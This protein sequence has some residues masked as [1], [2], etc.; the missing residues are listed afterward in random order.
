MI[1]LR[2]TTPQASA[3]RHRTLVGASRKT[4]LLMAAFATT[5]IGQNPIA[6]ER[7]TLEQAR[8]VLDAPRNT[9]IL[10]C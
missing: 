2:W 10:V 1:P 9:G 4:A 6:Q 7:H 8:E 3:V 5:G